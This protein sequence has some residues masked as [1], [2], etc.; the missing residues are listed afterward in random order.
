MLKR[1]LIIFIFTI[2]ATS[3]MNT[4]AQN[5]PYGRKVGFG[6]ILGEPIGLTAKVWT[7]NT[8]AFVFDLGNSYFGDLR[9][10][11]DYL[12]HFDAFRSKVAYLYAGP[13]GVV[14]FGEGNEFWYKG[15]YHRT[16]SNAGFGVRG[17]FGL[18][19]VPE[20]TPLEMFFEIGVLVGLA[21][22]V[23]SSVDGALGIRF[24]P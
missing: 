8:N 19:V 11:V 7:H 13:G 12:W 22:D 15:K 14:G 16:K 10:N 2:S 4:F 5:S 18:N 17:V 6:I 21:P 23:G 3:F 1:I 24:Y 9:V 20:R